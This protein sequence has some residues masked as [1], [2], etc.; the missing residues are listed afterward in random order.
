MGEGTLLAFAIIINILILQNPVE[1]LFRFFLFTR[2]SM[3]FSSLKNS[4]N[5]IN[6]QSPVPLNSD[7]CKFLAFLISLNLLNDEFELII[8][9]YPP[10]RGSY[11]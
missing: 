8:M 7:A 6:D 10:S 9:Y 3:K 1:W 11:F 2:I 5:L 4:K